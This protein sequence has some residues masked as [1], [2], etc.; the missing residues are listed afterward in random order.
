MVGLRARTPDSASTSRWTGMR[1]A[2]STLSGANGGTEDF[3]SSP[4][5][6]AI[7][8][9]SSCFRLGGY[10]V[11]S[12][13]GHIGDVMDPKGGPD[14]TSTAG[15]RQPRAARFSKFVAAQGCGAPPSPPMCTAAAGAPG[16]RHCAWLTH[17]TSGTP[18]CPT[19]ATR[20]T[21]S[22][23]TSVVPAPWP[24]TSARCSTSSG[25]SGDRIYDVIDAMA[26]GGSGDP[27]AGLDTH[28]RQELATLYRLGYPRGDEFMIA[29]PMGQ[30]WF[31]S[32]F[33]ERIQRDYPEYWEA[34][35]TKP[36][37]VG[38]DQP[39]VVQRD[40]IDV[41]ATVVRP[42]FPKELL[43]DERFSGPEFAQLRGLYRPLRRDARCMG[44]TDGSRAR[45]RAGRLPAR[46]GRARC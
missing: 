9:L 29:Q 20:S 4:L 24:S 1:G 7:G 19:W 41:R 38:F 31:W 3:F 15:G 14:P 2:C 46:H 33:A 16:D 11:E 32:S 40:L 45:R 44:C 39:E 22:S 6:E 25:C 43:D 17:P 26:P 42:L 13:M 18:P 35:W 34:F 27:F 30:I 21:G 5:G 8:G 28:Q 10:M 36:G 37:H 23:A 12:N